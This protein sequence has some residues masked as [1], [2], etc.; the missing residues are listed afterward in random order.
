MSRQGRE[1]KD[2]NVAEFYI[3]DVYLYGYYIVRTMKISLLWDCSRYRPVP[4]S[5]KDTNGSV[6]VLGEAQNKVDNDRD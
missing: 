5:K 4:K 2:K 3:F 1:R 6:L